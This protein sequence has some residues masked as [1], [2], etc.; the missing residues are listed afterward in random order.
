MS[1]HLCAVCNRF[2]PHWQPKGFKWGSPHHSS[3]PNLLQ[4]ADE[5]CYICQSITKSCHWRD[6]SYLT[7]KGFPF[8]FTVSLGTNYNGSHLTLTVEATCLTDDSPKLRQALEALDE[9]REKWLPKLGSMLML[10]SIS[11]SFH[12]HLRPIANEVTDNHEQ[13]STPSSVQCEPDMMGLLKYWFKECYNNHPYCRPSGPSFSPTRLLLIENEYS[14]RIVATKDCNAHYPYVALSHCWGTVSRLKLQKSNMVDLL[15]HISITELPTTYREGISV[16]LALGFS[17]IWIDSLCVIQ[18]D[19]K[20]WAE[21]AAMMKD[22]FEHCFIN[23]SATAAPDSLQSNFTHRDATSILLLEG[24]TPNR[25]G[26]KHG[27]SRFWLARS[28][29]DLRQEDIVHSPLHSRAWVFQEANLARRRID[30]ARSQ[31]WWHCQQHWACETHPSGVWSPE[32]YEWETEESQQYYNMCKRRDNHN[33]SLGMS[34]LSGPITSHTW[35]E[36]DYRRDW[37]GKI[38]RYSSCDITKTKDRLIAFSGIAQRYAQDQGH[39]LNDYLAGIWRQELPHYLLFRATHEKPTY[40]SDEYRAPS[41]SWISLEGPVR[42]PPPQHSNL[43]LSWSMCKVIIAKTIHQSER[44]KAGE[45]KGGVIHLKGCLVEVL[46]GSQ[47]P[48]WPGHPRYE[49]PATKIIGP[50]AFDERLNGKDSVSYLEHPQ[51]QLDQRKEG[52]VDG[53][54]RRSIS[55]QTLNELSENIRLFILPITGEIIYEEF[56]PV[57]SCLL[58]CQTSDDCVAG[59]DIYQRVGCLESVEGLKPVPERDIYII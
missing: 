34:S 16:T 27:P 37:L 4:A 3:L 43:L 59:S 46:L 10:G 23:L 7:F 48:K 20:D 29:V 18:D 17:Y 21:E 56:K 5:G 42:P 9:I 32:D 14:A 22:V 52:V 1:T 47:A 25:R 2:V 30:L 51:G 15:K 40:R 41:W 44:Y 24:E 53:A 13:I 36:G 50:G 26:E 38:H 31:M 55:F 19:E 45:V 28:W 49:G 33:A 54:V 12:F 11:F 8:D 35:F 6:I 39:D 58:L 57:F